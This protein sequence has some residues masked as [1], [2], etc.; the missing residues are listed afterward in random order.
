MKEKEIT[1]KG[2]Y[3]VRRVDQQFIEGGLR[4]KDKSCKIDYDYNNQIREY[5]KQNKKI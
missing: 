4:L 1:G 3:T 2:K 5:N